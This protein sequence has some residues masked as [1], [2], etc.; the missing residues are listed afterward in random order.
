MEKTDF[1]GSSISSN[2]N[3]P[4]ATRSKRS[5]PLLNTV[6]NRE[7]L[8][9]V[10]PCLPVPLSIGAGVNRCCHS[11]RQNMICSEK[12][13]TR[14]P[15]YKIRSLMKRCDKVASFLSSFVKQRPLNRIS[16]NKLIL[17]AAHSITRLSYTQ[18]QYFLK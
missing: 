16:Y 11:V 4:V 12:H 9:R 18:L 10:G 13:R 5:K 2:R 1:S 7:L 15:T 8:I 3:S 14:S 17:S 6:L